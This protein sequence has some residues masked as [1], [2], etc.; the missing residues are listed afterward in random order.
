MRVDFLSTTS[1]DK[2]PQVSAVLGEKTKVRLKPA[3]S[4]AAAPL[5]GDH[6]S[7]Y[8]PKRSHAKA[9]AVGRKHTDFIG[10]RLLR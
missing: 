4:H 2:K 7:F 8:G 5:G 1:V 10:R 9:M 6:H 3:P